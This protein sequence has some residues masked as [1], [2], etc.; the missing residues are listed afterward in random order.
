MNLSYGILYD[1]SPDCVLEGF[2]EKVSRVGCIL[3]QH[4]VE[5][6][7]SGTFMVFH[8]IPQGGSPEAPE[9]WGAGCDLEPMVANEEEVVTTLPQP[10]EM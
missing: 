2:V 3:V 5:W 8:P 10:S 1:T 9:F 7:D 6:S 4:Q